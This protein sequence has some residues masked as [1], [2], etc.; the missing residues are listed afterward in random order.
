MKKL[1]LTLLLLAVAFSI[2]SQDENLQVK[3]DSILAEADLLYRYEKSVWISTDLLLTDK[4]LEANYG[5]YVVSHSNDSVLVTYLNKK[6]D[7]VIARYTYVSA[8]LS[9]PAK[10]S[11]E[12]STMTMLEKELFD[13]KIKIFNQL[14]DSK[15]N[16]TFPQGF[17]PNL[18]LIKSENEFKLYIIMGTS[19]HGVIPFGN[20]YL[21]KTDKAGN[22]IYWKKFHSRFIPAESEMP[23]G[24]KAISVIHTHLKT[25]PYITATDICTFRLYK[26]LYEIEDF[27]VLCTATGKYYKYNPTTNK[28]EINEL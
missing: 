2:Y 22:I 7:A 24:E 20:D 21:F 17:N 19:Q 6:Q 4:K 28:I 9:H 10:I 15:Y 3:L 14:S 11:T 13:K 23:N 27:R 26:D 5:G 12:I 25:T 8:D 16:V 1:G 18:V